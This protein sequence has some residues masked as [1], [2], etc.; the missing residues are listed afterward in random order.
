MIL[1]LLF[2]LCVDVNAALQ[3]SRDGI[4]AGQWW[5][6][7]SGHFVHMNV[8]HGALN[9]AV[10]IVFSFSLGAYLSLLRWLISGI[11]IGLSISFCLFFFSP[12]VAWYVGFSGVLHGL[13]VMGLGYGISKSRDKLL[14][15]VLLLLVAKIVREQLPTFNRD[16]LSHWIDG[17]VVVDAHLYGVIAG[18]LLLM[19]F[20]LADFS[21]SFVGRKKT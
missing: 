7:I 1:L 6:L 13:L 14:A 20:L 3:F 19:F 18:F 10:F 4:Q 2:L 21:F 5:R 11:V 15:V 8:V 16:H 9:V 12:N 17:A